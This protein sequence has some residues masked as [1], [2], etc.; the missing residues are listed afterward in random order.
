MSL[1]LQC[2]LI[3]PGQGKSEIFLIDFGSDMNIKILGYQGNPNWKEIAK[4]YLQAV[5]NEYPKYNVYIQ[6]QERKKISRAW[7]L[8]DDLG[9][10]FKFL[11]F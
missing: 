5:A 6:K 8:A 11:L 10:K 7:R 1:N 9:G 3:L 4:R 2:F